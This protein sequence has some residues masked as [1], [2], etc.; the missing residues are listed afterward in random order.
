[1]F[2]EACPPLSALKG[3]L[4]HTLGAAGVVE[5]IA[6]V[7][8]MQERLLPGTPR[9]SSPAEGTPSS[10]VKEPRAAARLDYVLKLNTGFGGVN[11][12]LVLGS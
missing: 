3:M 6:C 7:L 4:G 8:A 9:L 10:L 5:T 12:A 2:G 11:G 1:V